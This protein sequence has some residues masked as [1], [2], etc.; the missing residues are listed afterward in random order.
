MRV[1]NYCAT[2]AELLLRLLLW[3]VEQQPDCR[4]KCALTFVFVGNKQCSSGDRQVKL[5]REI[6]GR[7]TYNSTSVEII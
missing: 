2:N 6:D 3:V 7:H 4:W 1:L 5:R